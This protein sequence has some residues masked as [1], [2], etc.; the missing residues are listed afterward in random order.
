METIDEWILDDWEQ[1]EF[2]D[3]IEYKSRMRLSLT[4]NCWITL[5][6]E[7]CLKIPRWLPVLLQDMSRL[8]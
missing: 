5:R 6:V 1:A 3:I 7:N 8:I 2:R 4:Y